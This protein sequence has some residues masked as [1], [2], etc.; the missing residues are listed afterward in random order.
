MKQKS[1]K[2]AKSIIAGVLLA[3][4]LMS[5]GLSTVGSYITQGIVASAADVTVVESGSCGAEGNNVVYT[6]DSEG[7]LIISGSGKMVSFDWWG[8]STFHNDSN[9]KQVII[10]D[11]VT[12]I[13]IDAFDGFT[14][15]TSITIPDSVTEIGSGAF[16]NTAWYNNQPDGLVYAGKVV[17]EYKGEM[18]E[19]TSIQLKKG[20]VGIAD[21][22]F[23]YC[24]GL[25]SITIPD[26]VTSIGDYAFE[27]CTGLTSITIPDSVKSIGNGAFL[28]CTGLTSITISDSVTSIGDDAFRNCTGLVSIDVDKN[29]TVYSSDNGVLLNKD[30]TTV[31]LCPR[32]KKGTYTIPDSVTSI[33]DDAFEYCTGL[34]SITI[35]DSVT[36]ISYYA[37]RIC[38]GLVSIDV[39]KNNTVYSS[40]NGVLLNKDKTTIILCP[41]CKKGTYTIPNS[42]TS[43]GDDA[44]YGCTGL[45]SI[46]IPDSVTS[47]GDDAFEDCTGLTSI[48]IPDSVTSI[49]DDAFEYC[50]GLTSITIPNSVT[51]IG[52]DAFYGCTGLTS[53]TIPDSVTE[54]G[55]GAFYNTAWYNNQP[56][57]LVYAGKVVY[58]Y[59]GEMPENTSIQLKKGTVGIVDDAFYDCTDLTSITIPNSVTSIGDCAF[60]GCTGL[61]SITIPDSVMEI[62]LSAF[63]DCTDLTSVEISDSVTEIGGWAFDD[64]TWYNNQTDG[65]IYLGKVAYKY[66]GEMPENISIQLK[67][68]TVSI[69]GNA[70]RGCSGLISVEIPDSVEKIGSAA[71]KGCSNLKSVKI[72]D[73]VTFIGWYAFGYMS[74][75]G[76]DPAK[77]DGFVIYGV[78]GSAAEIYANE[79]NMTF[80][81]I[82][83]KILGD[84]NGD[85]SVDIADALMIAR[86]DAGLVELDET[87]LSVSDVNTDDSVDIADALMVARFD[88][89]LIDSLS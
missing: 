69:S 12:S 15:L 3:C 7:T 24:T 28:R 83:N 61:T 75:F 60:Y 78:S 70:F 81:E 87:Q 53:I 64:T 20:T 85:E 5:G 56:D 44:F 77:T 88:A 40:D 16:Y 47:I 89:G 4:M 6:L 19:N 10:K 2:T 29:N 72:P 68:D 1:K 43:I 82:Q 86:Y 57:G 62:G 38:T 55:S 34:T 36:S 18:P 58:E 73:S 23:E 11:G 37:F 41:E 35:P 9:I 14:G 51:S 65:L 50:T 67:N 49:G 17:Y 27:Y 45:T 71:F 30:K 79:N 46:T 26:S 8:R 54:I 22:A 76:D 59:K 84:T 52:D 63:E 13:G 21:D 32:G 42:V 80:V 31:I 66:K 74:Y 33:G 39:D 48:T 25:T